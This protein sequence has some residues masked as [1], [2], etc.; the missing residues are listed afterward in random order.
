MN[1]NTEIEKKENPKVQAKKGGRP[2]KEKM[3]KIKESERLK[4][5][6]E[7]AQYKEK[8]VRLYAE[9]ENA[10]KRMEREKQDFFRY[11]NEKLIVE[12]LGILDDLERS[13]ESAKANHQDYTAFVKGIE[14][15]MAHIHEMLKKNGVKPIEVKGKLFDP[16]AH[17]VL[18]QEE[19]EELDDGM[20]IDELQKGYTL[21]EKVVRTAKVK[22]A[23]KI[24]SKEN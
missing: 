4:L 10:R 17:E 19:T 23:K 22:V 3:I 2:L 11:A 20:V 14:M 13:V 9:F 12:F 16:H 18:L 24:Q 21:G 15:V 7:G 1:K 6:E 8:Y 5:V